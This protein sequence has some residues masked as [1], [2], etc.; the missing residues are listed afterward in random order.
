MRRSLSAIAIVIGCIAIP[1]AMGDFQAAL[2]ENR[3]G[4]LEELS[5]HTGWIMIGAVTADHKHWAASI[6]NDP[7]VSYPAGAYEILGRRLDRRKPILP[8]VGDKIRVTVRLPITIF[9]FRSAGE[10]HRLTAPTSV[11][12]GLISADDST[13]GFVEPGTVVIVRDVRV[14]RGGDIRIIWARVSPLK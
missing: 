1:S 3:S 10:K 2:A 13:G 14:S 8:G 7:S 6:G 4:S 5:H 12:R 9:D 11:T